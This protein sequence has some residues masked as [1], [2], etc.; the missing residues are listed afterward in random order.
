MVPETGVE[1]ATFALRNKCARMLSI[2]WWNDLYMRPDLT[3]RIYQNCFD[4]GDLE[5]LVQMY[6]KAAFHDTST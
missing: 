3:R 6:S 4:T 5:V 1:P 2:I